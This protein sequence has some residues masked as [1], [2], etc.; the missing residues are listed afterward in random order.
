M[1]DMPM[2]SNP[3]RPGE[4]D[5]FSYQVSQDTAIGGRNQLNR[6]ISQKQ[7]AHL[8]ASFHEPLSTSQ[9]LA[10]DNTRESQNYYFTHV[11]EDRSSDTQ[12]SYQNGIMV[13]AATNEHVTRSTQVLK[14]VLGILTDD[15]TTPEV[16]D[17]RHDLMKP[18]HLR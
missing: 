4:V 13:G 17:T 16:Y 14:Y 15:S 18:P 11:S 1:T 6:S 3:M 5:T 10:L 9:P 7:H 2:S 8:E 12:I